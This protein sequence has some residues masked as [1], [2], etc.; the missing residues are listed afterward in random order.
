MKMHFLV[1]QVNGEVTDRQE[2]ETATIRSRAPT[3]RLLE[4]CHEILHDHLPATFVEPFEFTA[5]VSEQPPVTIRWSQIDPFSANAL[6]LADDEPAGL[7]WV[8]SGCQPDC[9]RMAVEMMIDCQTAMAEKTPMNPGPALR[10][11][12]VR[13]VAI[14]IPLPTEANRRHARVIGNFSVA[15]AT[16][17]LETVFDFIDRLQAAA[18]RHPAFRVRPPSGFSRN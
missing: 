10:S 4:R 18:R 8:L 11:V 17:F 13:P 12:S 9:D 5:R 16:A 3:L 2:I 14:C 15:M 1:M 7:L 6:L